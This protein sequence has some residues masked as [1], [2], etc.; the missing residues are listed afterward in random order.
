M[1]TVHEVVNPATEQV[2]R[3]VELATVEQTDEAIARAS[4]AAAGWR[5]VSP[6]DKG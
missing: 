1:S 5:A 2:V 4:A 6:A 3:T